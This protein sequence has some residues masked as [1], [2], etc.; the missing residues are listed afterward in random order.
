MLWIPNPRCRI[1]VLTVILGGYFKVCVCLNRRLQA[2]DGEYG[3]YAGNGRMSNKQEKSNMGDYSWWEGDSSER[4]AT[5]LS[6]KLPFLIDVFFPECKFMLNSYWK[7]ES[8]S[9]MKNTN[10]N[11]QWNNI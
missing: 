5:F 11:Y 10:Q 1:C 8:F 9:Y 7:E 3:S 6:Y 2:L 4:L